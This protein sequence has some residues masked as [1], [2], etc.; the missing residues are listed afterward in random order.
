M[1]N[2]LNARS[3]RRLDSVHSDLVRVVIRAAE[4]S[5]ITFQITEGLRSLARQKALKVRGASRTLRSRHLTG[6]AVDVVA[7]VGKTISW[8]FPLYL[9]IAEAFK[10]AA[11]ELDIAIQ[12]GGDWKT[13][14]DG[15]HFQL[16]WRIYPVSN[17]PQPK[18]V[19]HA[20]LQIGTA[21]ARVIDLQRF[22]KSSGL[23]I[24]IDGDFGPR[25][26]RAVMR[27]QAMHGLETDG[28]AGR[29]TWA[30]LKAIQRI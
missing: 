27:F 11:A 14:R 21:G 6:H 8:S 22:L 17:S 30:A 10:R 26:H 29:K 23:R 9:R 20:P 15:P 2:K 18:G 13:L 19:D 7:Y 25:T 24:Q 5:P 3:M 1:A 16:P 12:W 28:I 4:I